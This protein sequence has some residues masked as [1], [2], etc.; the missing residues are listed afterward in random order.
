VEGK[1]RK[2][3]IAK[4][5]GR[6]VPLLVTV[7]EAR[8]NGTDVRACTDEQEDDEQEGLEVEQRRLGWDT[9]GWES[10]QLG[11]KKSVWKETDHG[12]VVDVVC[13]LARL[14][15]SSW[16]LLAFIYLSANYGELSGRRVK[17]A[18]AVGLSS[19]SDNLTIS[20]LSFRVWP[21]RA[22][23]P[24]SSLPSINLGSF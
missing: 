23:V 8:R 22:T 14:G 3:R 18:T 15:H 1:G 19:D 21:H 9:G 13:S 10:R 24:S 20:L 4:K 17:A 2:S 12:V 7:N 11:L 16:R 6:H 5:S